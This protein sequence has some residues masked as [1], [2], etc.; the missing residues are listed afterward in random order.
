[1][2][3]AE[4]TPAVASARWL[5]RTWSQVRPRLQRLA[6]ESRRLAGRWRALP[7][8]VR[9][10]SS[11]GVAILAL[12][13]VWWRV[14]MAGRNEPPR[15]PIYE[16]APPTVAGT[17][18]PPSNPENP[19]GTPRHT[20][21]GGPRN[22]TSSGATTPRDSG[23]RRSTT[24]RNAPEPAHLVINSTPWGVLYIDDRQYGNLPQAG[25]QDVP[26]GSHTIKILR[27]GYLPYERPIVIESGET[28]RLTDIVLVEKPQ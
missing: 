15:G 11:A 7:R 5:G 14:A 27:D 28:L 10:T 9:Y 2:A 1:G 19:T 17:T 22:P 25:L 23:A 12:A 3:A 6:V 8:N 24:G 21:S 26:P 16:P 18:P 4:Q 20:P 13:F